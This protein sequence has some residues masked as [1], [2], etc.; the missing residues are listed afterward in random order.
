MNS[1]RQINRKWRTGL[2][3]LAGARRRPI[4]MFITAWVALVGSAQA[5]QPPDVVQSDGLANTAMGT[6]ALADLTSGYFNTATG[7]EALQSNTTGYNNTA[8]G[9]EALWGNQ[10]GYDNTASGVQALYSNTSG[11]YNTATGYQTLYLNQSGYYDTAT[12]A[13]ALY[14]N[15]T[16]HHNTATG[17]WA[18]YSNTQGYHNTATGVSALG[19]NTSAYDNTADGDNALASNTLGNGNT[20]VGSSALA[21]SIGAVNTAVGYYALQAT[22][23]SNNIGVGNVAG[24]NVTTGS[25][26]IEIGSQGSS[27]DGGVIRIGTPGTQTQT[28]IA[29]ISGAKVTGAA[30]YVTSSGQLGVL[31][32]S[33]RYKTAITPMGGR[34]ERLQALRPV[35]FHLKSDPK[36]A[37][38]YG[39]IAEEVAK[40]YPELVIRNEKGRI[41]G[42]RYDELAP[43]LLN[44]LQQEQQRVARLEAQLSE[45]YTLKAQMSELQEL[46]AQLVALQE[47]GE[48]KGVRV[49]QLSASR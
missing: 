36:G 23:G 42:V 7:L 28:Y 39:L 11:T 35:T 25:N 43:M 33:E 17:D 48:L 30:V 27:G 31:A 49:A 13:G 18:L 29:G 9:A 32:S 22:T 44:E 24:E 15:T 26:N 8:T 16:G 12:G 14:S 46:K 19:S 4:A 41:E 34:T 1:D 5:A 47:S 37:L 40:V 10:N 2:A 45:L 20:A 38:Q 3:T 6:Y 21:S